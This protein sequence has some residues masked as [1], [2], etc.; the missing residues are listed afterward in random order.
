[1]ACYLVP[2]VRLIR[3]LSAMRTR[4][5]ILAS[6]TL[7]AILPGCGGTGTAPTTLPSTNPTTRPS[8]QFEPRKDASGKTGYYIPRD[9]DDALVEVDRIFVS[10]GKR[11]AV[12]NGTEEDMIQ[13]H[14]GL[15]MW[16]RNNW[17]LWG[18]SRLSEYFN[19]IGIHHPD[20]MSGIIL[21]SYWRKLHGK[22]IDLEGQVKYYEEYWR[23]QK[24]G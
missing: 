14:F 6:I 7:A 3:E 18:G 5:L 17:G 21:D 20:D 19:G 13:Y 10:A 4:R 22:P 2:L 1:M 11:D 23:R 24:G 15:G 8:G 9:L 16:M 12:M